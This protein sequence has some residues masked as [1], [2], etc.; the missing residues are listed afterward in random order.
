MNEWRSSH[1]AS[2]APSSA[3]LDPVAEPVRSADFMA[4]MELEDVPED[5]MNEQERI[6]YE[7]RGGDSGP[8]AAATFAGEDGDDDFG[9]GGED[10]LPERF[11]MGHPS[12]QGQQQQQFS[13]TPGAPNVVPANA[14]ARAQSLNVHSHLQQQQRQQIQHQFTAQHQQHQPSPIVAQ[15]QPQLQINAQQAQSASA[16]A[17]ASLIPSPYPQVSL[18]QQQQ[19][20]AT[21][22]HQHHQPQAQA[23]Q[24]AQAGF[25]DSDYLPPSFDAIAAAAAGGY[26]NN[27]VVTHQQPLATNEQDA[28]KLAAWNAHL[29]S[30]ALVAQQQQRD[31]QQQQQQF[32]IQFHTPPPSSHG[33][34]ARFGSNHQATSQQQQQ[35]PNPNQLQHFQR[36]E[37]ANN[38]TSMDDS[39]DAT[40]V[41]TPSSHASSAAPS[42]SL[43]LSG[44]SGAS[45][46][47][48]APSSAGGSAYSGSIPPSLASPLHDL[49]L[50]GAQQ[51]AFGGFAYGSAPSAGANWGSVGFRKSLV[52]TPVVSTP[53]IAVGG[54]GGG[55]FPMMSMFM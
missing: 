36:A 35:Q 2:P 22:R 25:S 52:G 40:S 33:S 45:T 34:T 5:S 29:F 11:V 53:P 46:G 31:Q 21:V 20:Y 26:S 48:G 44:L 28:T 10:D 32:G 50:S 39:I 23:M 14:G 17:A 4:L 1:P 37:D 43:S 55:Q 9:I 12:T 27:T 51:D 24:V 8:L 7:M 42:L 18:Q 13:M 19:Q 15:F 54:G 30:T 38:Y 6:A 16:A 49:S 3:S 41:S 47:S